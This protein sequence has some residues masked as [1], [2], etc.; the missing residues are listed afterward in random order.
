MATSA[1]S[2]AVIHGRDP[3]VN[4]DEFLTEADALFDEVFA[5]VDVDVARVAPGARC[6]L[7]NLGDREISDELYCGPVRLL[8]YDEPWFTMSFTTNVRDD[9]VVLSE[10]VVGDYRSPTGTL[11]RPDGQEPDDP[12]SLAP[13]DGPRTSLKDFA[14]LVPLDAV[15]SIELNGIE[16]P[17]EI[18]APAATVTVSAQVVLEHIPVPVLGAL[19]PSTPLDASLY[20]PAENQT[21]TGWQIDIADPPDLGP[22]DEYSAWAAREQ[23]RDAS[24]S[25]AVGVGSQRLAVVGG[26]ADTANPLGAQDGDGVAKIPCAAV[27]CTPPDPARYLLVVSSSSSEEPALVAMTD[28]EEEIVHLAGGEVETEHSRA[29]YSDLPTV[30]QV[31]VAWGTKTFETVSS[32]ERGTYDRSPI[33]YS[34]GGDIASVYRT[35]FDA[36][37]GWAPDGRAWLVVPLQNASH[38][39]R[40]TDSSLNW[41][42]SW[43]AEFGDEGIHA[44]PATSDD[45]RAVFLVDS[46]ATTFTVSFRP[47]GSIE[48]SRI[49]TSGMTQHR[50]TFSAPEVLTFDVSFSDEAS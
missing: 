3:I 31:S 10:P 13:P 24:L 20:R 28:G 1:C 18:R 32:E 33:S 2:D 48:Y 15:R 23:Y 36:V 49:D 9:E 47:V 44:E 16:K 38:G 40:G 35:P 43:V 30:R 5:D 39:A 37:H 45:D 6:Y 11:F 14:A 19:D 46:D 50:K 21:L 12:A 8:G 25:L 4:A 26:P 42:E 17:A 41:S 7:E 22:S 34:Y 29:A 27:P